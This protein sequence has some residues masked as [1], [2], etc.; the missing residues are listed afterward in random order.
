M[1]VNFT[2]RHFEPSDALKSF[3]RDRI[4][5]IRK[6]LDQAGEANVVLSVEKHVH[7]A[8]ILLKSGPFIVRGREKTDDMYASIS[9]AMD[10][11]ERQIK[12][13]KNRMRQYKPAGH[14]SATPLKFRKTFIEAPVLP[15]DESEETQT[16]APSK[17][18]DTKEVIALR[19]TVDEAVLQMELYEHDF[20]VFTNAE[21]G[22][23]SVLYRR[24]GD[25]R[26]GLIDTAAV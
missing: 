5:S 4:E 26:F 3:S 9:A 19:M 2:F 21:T 10:K 18:V 14:H 13:Y 23:V 1:Q 15:V 12:R 6:Y 24:K 22:N 16:P 7:H 8:E 17:I 25:G 20:L 11:V